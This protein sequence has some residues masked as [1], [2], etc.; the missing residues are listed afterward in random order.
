M[1]TGKDVRPHHYE[2]AH[3]ALPQMLFA[4]IDEN[5][6]YLI[7]APQKFIDHLWGFVGRKVAQRGQVALSGAGPRV[8]RLALNPGVMWV[9]ELPPCEAM[10]E[11]LYVGIV[12]IRPQGT[13][14]ERLAIFTLEYSFDLTTHEQYYVLCRWT[15]GGSHQN[16]GLKVPANVAAFSEAVVQQLRARN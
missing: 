4:S 6:G 15:A 3:R 12:P 1:K 2:F 7:D 11:A 10:A 14:D 8:E 13:P 5:L 9:V 16:C